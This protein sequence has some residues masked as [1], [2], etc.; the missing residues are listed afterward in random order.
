MPPE[1]VDYDF[2]SSK[3][4][5]MT[6]LTLSVEYNLVWTAAQAGMIPA[7]FRQLPYDEQAEL[8]AFYYVQS[9][10]KSFYADEQRAIAEKRQRELEA[11]AR[12]N[13]QKRR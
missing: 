1:L 6:E 4:D 3:P 10:I 5:G 12:T 8:M 7:D 9:R 2:A 13:S 11:K